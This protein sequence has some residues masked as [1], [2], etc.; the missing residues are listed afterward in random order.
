MNVF[1]IGSGEIFIIVIVI[2]VFVGPSKMPEVAGQVGRWVRDFR[3]MSADLTGEFEKTLN[4]SGAGELRRTLDRD[5]KGMRSQV[6]NVGRSV[7]RDL[8]GKKSGSTTKSGAKPGTAT[9]RAAGKAAGSASTKATATG[10][11]TTGTSSSSSTAKAASAKASAKSGTR[12]AVRATKADPLADLIE[13]D[14][15]APTPVRSVPRVVRRTE[16]DD[17]ITIDVDESVSGPKEATALDRARQRRA[18]AAYN[19]A[20][21]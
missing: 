15:S 13:L 11:K 3:K 14:F 6:E 17:P 12:S 8:G 7:E 21:A 18:S 2:L 5:L 20:R 10:T 16:D 19:R 1:G 9:T 4:E